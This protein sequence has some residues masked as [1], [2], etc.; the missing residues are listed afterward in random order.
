MNRTL[1]AELQT[2]RSYPSVTLLL[3]TTP[4]RPLDSTQMGNA[5]R[6]VDQVDGRLENETDNALRAVLVTKLI[7]LLDEAATDYGGHALALCVSPTYSATVQLGQPVNERVIIDETFATRDLVADL[8]RTA[9]Y[10][11]VTVSDRTTRLFVGDRQ[12]LG[13]ERTDSWPLIREPEQN[14]HSW[15]RAMVNAF[16]CEHERYPLPTVVA[17]SERSVRQVLRAVE[18]ETIGA[19]PGNHDRTSWVDLHHHAWPLVTDWLRADKTR[20]MARL[21]E[22]RS[23]C[24][25]AGG[26]SEIWPLANEGRIELLIVEDTYVV[27]ARLDGNH[28]DL[29]VDATAHGVIDDL[30]DETIEAVMAKGGSAVIVADGVLHECDRIAAIVRY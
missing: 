2:Q 17:G 5:K 23:Q 8:N 14:P 21:D 15:T 20:A 1:L 12:R 29:A 4:R 24:R 16:K 9:L 7:E 13:E 3:N 30:I 22:A 28:F 27:A 10:R 6:L 25:F 18:F 11:V 19:I 26:I